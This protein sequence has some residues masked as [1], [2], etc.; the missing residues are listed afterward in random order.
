MTRTEN[1]A[2]LRTTLGITNTKRD[3]LIGNAIDSCLAELN[4]SIGILSPD[5]ADPRIFSAIILY[6][7]SQPGLNDDAV[8]RVEYRKRYDDMRGSLQLSGSYG[9]MT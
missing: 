6:V 7:C 4:D 1:V 9:G 8:A 2:F 3:G 5:E